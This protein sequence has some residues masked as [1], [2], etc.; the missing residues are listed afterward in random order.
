MLDVIM[1]AFEPAFRIVEW[2][3][4]EMVRKPATLRRAQ[5]EV[6]QV[7]RMKG[8]INETTLEEMKYVKA[9]FKETL[10][11]HPPS[12]FLAPREC[13][14]TCEINGYTIP[15][16]T[17]VL[18]NIWAITRD[19][20]Y[21]S[22]SFSSSSSSAEEE[23]FVPERF[24]DSSVDYRGSNFEFISFGAGKRVCPGMLF[25]PA[26]AEILLA[27]L[28][29]YFDWQLPSGTTP[30]TLDMTELLDSTLKKKTSLILVPT[31][32]GNPMCT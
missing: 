6:R 15:K 12:P 13:M 16:R 7:L 14:E 8:H 19:P 20:K 4:A 18:V 3:M 17:Q 32:H 23:E 26:I 11:L 27:N 31:P 2:A 29:C 10:R 24:M 30:E 21:W 22:S 1:A 25:G 9:V 28:L 5:E